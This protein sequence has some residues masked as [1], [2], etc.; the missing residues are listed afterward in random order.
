METNQEPILQIDDKKYIISEL[1]Q[2]AQQI[3]AKMQVTQQKVGS[4]E[5]EAEQLKLA[6]D[7]Y[8]AA[9]QTHLPEDSEDDTVEVVD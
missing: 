5:F 8:R 9:L 1:S 7:G 4:L 6:L 3:I 2:E